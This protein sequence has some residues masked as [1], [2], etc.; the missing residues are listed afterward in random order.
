MSR[1]K[2][3]GAWVAA[4][5]K[6]LD[7]N[8]PIFTKRKFKW[9]FCLTLQ[10][11]D[12]STRQR[13]LEMFL[14]RSQEKWNDKVMEQKGHKSSTEDKRQAVILRCA[15]VSRSLTLKLG[16]LWRLWPRIWPRSNSKGKDSI[17][18]KRWRLIFD[19]SRE[20]DQS[21]LVAVVDTHF[22]SELKLALAQCFWLASNSNV[23]NLHARHYPRSVK[24]GA[25]HHTWSGLQWL[26]RLIMNPCFPPPICLLFLC[27]LPAVL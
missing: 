13:D 18:E 6:D 24:R 14:E 5:T 12:N 11:L 27:P 23:L 19:Q 15:L 7:S 17:R 9:Q 10:Y 26:F 25:P 8:L 16:S 22:P 2:L 20:E 21:L 3:Q 1:L 4:E